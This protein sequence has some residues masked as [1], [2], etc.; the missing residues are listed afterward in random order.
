L[1]S[2]GKG[3][4]AWVRSKTEGKT[5]YLRI[6][7]SLKL[8]DVGGKVVDVGA[9]FMEVETDGKRW[10]VGL[11]ESLADAFQRSANDEAKEDEAKDEPKVEAKDEVQGDAKD[12]SKDDAKDGAKDE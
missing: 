4:Q 3:P 10:T 7:D 6:G 1:V 8:G 9:N 5:L 11:D 2:D 12:E